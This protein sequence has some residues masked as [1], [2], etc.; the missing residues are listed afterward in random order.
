MN[1][2]TKKQRLNYGML[3]AHAFWLA[4]KLEDKPILPDYALFGLQSALKVFD[5]VYLWHYEPVENA[6]EGV[7]KQD[8]AMLL[9]VTEKNILMMKNITV[10]HISDIVRFKAAAMLGGWVI[11]CDNFWLRSPP[12][13]FVFTTLW[14]KRTGGVAPRSNAWKNMAHAFAKEDWDG[15]DSINTPFSVD[16]DTE[17]AHALM[18]MVNEFVRKALVGNAWTVPPKKDQW[19]VLM[20]GLRQLI[21]SH[22]M[23]RFVR[24]PIEYGVAPY[25]GGFADKILEDGYFD[26]EEERRTKFGVTFPST[27][28]ILRTAFCIPTSFAL[29]ERNGLYNGLDIRLFAENHP[30]SLL[31]QIVEHITKM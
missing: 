16:C 20:W 25:W 6:P 12:E 10:A 11:D 22:N 17:F 4:R 5:K 7:F 30:T 26:L 2:V 28:E 29:S 3:T 21:L 14:A 19:N 1:P 27:E 8:A 13:G 31:G 24:P 9:S 18:V 15:G 23:G